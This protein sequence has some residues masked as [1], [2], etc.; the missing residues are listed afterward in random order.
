MAN[1][2][3]HLIYFNTYLFILFFEIKK[4]LLLL[5]YLLSKFS[6]FLLFFLIEQIT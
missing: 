5:V 1:I 3:I 4:Y 2:I 6:K